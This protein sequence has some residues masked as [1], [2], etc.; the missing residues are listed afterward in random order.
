MLDGIASG[1]FRVGEAL[2]AEADLAS[3]LEVSRPTMREVIRVLVDRGVVRVVHGRGTYL[4]PQ[5]HWTDMAT[6]VAMVSRRMSAR[7]VGEYLVEIRRMIE[8]GSSG[9][10][11]RRATEEDLDAMRAELD[12]FAAASVEDDAATCADADL[13]FHDCVFRAS[14]NPFLPAIIKPLEAALSESRRRTSEVTEVR[15][16]AAQHHQVIFA[17][18]ARGDEEA[19]KNAMRAH[20]KQTRDDIIRFLD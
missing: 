11:A 2:P 5:D 7:E 20:M 8:V 18:I 13:S 9:H 1:D 6:L 17:A 4:N 16:R 19:A 14:R 15:D 10:A 3:Y 12:R